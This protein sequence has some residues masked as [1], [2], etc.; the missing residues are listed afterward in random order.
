MSKNQKTVGLPPKYISCSPLSRT[1]PEGWKDIMFRR[2]G[3]DIENGV[4]Y[5]ACP[6]CGRKFDFSSIDHLQGDHIW[7]YS[8]FGDTTWENYQL[9]CGECNAKKRDRLEGEVRRVL[10]SGKFR[11]LVTAFLQK[12]VETGELRKDAVI[13]NIFAAKD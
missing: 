5:Y 13:K 8:L 9:I 10:G 6:I 11:E 12:K 7:P 3:K 2:S 4:P 1:F